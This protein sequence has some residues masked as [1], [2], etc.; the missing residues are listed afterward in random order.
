[1]VYADG[2]AGL[3]LCAKSTRVVQKINEVK[4][5][6]KKTNQVKLAILHCE[7]CLLRRDTA[8]W[9]VVAIVI[10]S[11]LYSLA[12]GYS[13]VERHRAIIK[14]ASEEEEARLAALQIQ[15]ASIEAGEP[16]PD[17]PWRDPRN[18]LSVGGSLAVTPAVL[19]LKPLAI[20]AIGQS[21][22][23]PPVLKISTYS[24]ENFLFQDET[25]NPLHLLTGGFDL[26]FV[27][28]FILP[29]LILALSYN[30]VSGEREQGTLALLASCC[31]VDLGKIL[32]LR[33]L[34]RAGLLLLILLPTVVVGLTY[35][36]SL[37]D[38]S[39]LLW[40]ALAIVF[41]GI[42]W[43]A[44][45][46]AVNALE[47]DSTYNAMLL[48]A[49]WI[50]WLLLIPTAINALT[51]IF[52]PAPARSE[53][54]LAARTASVAAN[55]KQDVVLARLHSAHSQAVP[56]PEDKAREI[57]LRRLAVQQAAHT[58][59]DAVLAAHEAQ[60]KRRQDFV[61]RLSYSSPA[62]LLYDTLAELAGTG[63]TRYRDY[64]SQVEA[65]HQSWRRFFES[66]AERNQQLTTADFATFPRFD[67]MPK[68][69]ASAPERVAST[70]LALGTL[71]LLGGIAAIVGLRRCRIFPC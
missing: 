64:L 55:H 22:I 46:G 35:F 40:L 14:A 34:V 17:K 71:A 24:K 36:D 12:N 23:Y 3:L 28:V 43:A 56:T 39:T 48:T 4:Q 6:S 47:K 9:L 5:K 69:T 38:L 16:A 18:P 7:W 1:L 51:D 65:F 54:A 45:A 52:Y 60:L 68:K 31:P 61:D 13:R 25:E 8:F 53:M 63:V 58:H 21:D 20:I 32:G 27:V 29:L 33:L 57:D 49:A 44:L 30:L 26:T 70:L 37:P 67:F 59:S 50:V 11:T 15:L 42:F 66:R 41:Y 2:A 10:G 62:L 19:S